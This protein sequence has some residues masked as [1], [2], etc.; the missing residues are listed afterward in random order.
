MGRTNSFVLTDNYKD[1]G[2]NIACNKEIWNE[3]F[4][5]FFDIE[6]ETVL[7]KLIIGFK[8]YSTGH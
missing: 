2:Q 1:T 3:N 4:D 5:N 6:N 8:K 7:G